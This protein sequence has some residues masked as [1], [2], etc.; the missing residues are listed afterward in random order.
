[1][2]G[3]GGGGG[4]GRGGC[5]SRERGGEYRPIKNPTNNIRMSSLSHIKASPP[6]QRHKTVLSPM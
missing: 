2:T 3:G 6:D 5:K 4:G 1:V